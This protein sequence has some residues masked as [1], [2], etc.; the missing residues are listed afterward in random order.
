[1]W[2]TKMTMTIKE[3]VKMKSYEQIT[4]TLSATFPLS[5]TEVSQKGLMIRNRLFNKEISNTGKYKVPFIKIKLAILAEFHQLK[6]V[7]K[8]VET[9]LKGSITAN[10]ECGSY[11]H[12]TFKTKKS[13]S[14]AIKTLY[15]DEQVK[16]TFNRTESKIDYEITQQ[17][18]NDI[19]SK[20]NSFTLVSFKDLN[21]KSIDTMILTVLTTSQGGKDFN[22]KEG[23]LLSFIG[24]DY[25]VSSSKRKHQRTHLRRVMSRVSSIKK[26]VRNGFQYTINTVEKAVVAVKNTVK[27]VSGTMTKAEALNELKLLREAIA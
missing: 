23:V 24:K 19:T 17:Y 15:Q 18:L 8:P 7:G 9:I 16:I 6:Q 2:S 26:I 14:D 5:V 12:K 10:F 22:H 20:S 1:M 11:F 25:R 21:T 13:L 4:K 3:I 27:V